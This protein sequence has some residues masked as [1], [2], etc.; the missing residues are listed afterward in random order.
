MCIA[1]LGW[2]HVTI[3][4]TG[5]ASSHSVEGKGVIKANYFVDKNSLQ[6]VRKIQQKFQKG[7][8]IVSQS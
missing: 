1:Q 3:D 8:A 7:K 5:K 2:Q 4:Q 6:F